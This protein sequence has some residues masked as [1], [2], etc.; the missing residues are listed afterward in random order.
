MRHQKGGAPIVYNLATYCTFL[1]DDV[2]RARVHKGWRK[3]GAGE[4]AAGAPVYLTNIAR[5][6]LLRHTF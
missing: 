6:I 3:G 4:G 5:L 2:F 1:I